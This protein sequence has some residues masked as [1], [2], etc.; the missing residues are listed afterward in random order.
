MLYLYAN[1][2][3]EE[4][5]NGKLSNIIK[6]SLLGV[7]AVMLISC[8]HTLVPIDG[9]LYRGERLEAENLKVEVI[10]GQYYMEFDRDDLFI[11]VHVIIRNHTDHKVQIGYKNFLMLDDHGNKYKPADLQD[12]ITYYRVTSMN[13]YPYYS[14]YNW[15]Y[16][17]YNPV[18]WNHPYSTRYYIEMIRETYLKQDKLEPEEEVSGFLYFKGAAKLADETVT[19]V[20]R[21]AENDMKPVEYVFKID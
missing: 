14:S 19:L 2:L 1:L 3:K 15:H 13:V 18:R 11:P 9:P 17:Y 20:A 21:F 4:Q 12:V 7:T 10:P 5:M 6:M 8:S 16:P